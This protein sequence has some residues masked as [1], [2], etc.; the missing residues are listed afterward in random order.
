MRPQH[1]QSQDAYH[2][3]RTY[4]A[5]SILHP[6][7]YG[8]QDII[9]DST[10]LA[11]GQLRL[12]KLRAVLTDGD[13]FN[14][15]GLDDLPAEVALDA[16]FPKNASS[17]VF[18]IA[19]AALRSNARNAIKEG[20]KPSINSRYYPFE[21]EAFDQF[22]EASSG[23]VKS[24]KRFVQLMVQE[25][26]T[27]LTNLVC[28]P[29]LQINRK[30]TGGYELD[31]KYIPS[32]TSIDASPALLL[33]LRQLQGTLKAK[34]DA[35]YGLH[36]EPSKNVIEFRSGDVAS[37]WLLHTVSSAHASLA[38]L[39][40]HSALHPERLFG[41]LLS[42]A[43]GLLTFAKD[44]ASLK[45]GLPIY[46]HANPG[47]AFTRL[48]ALIR[49]LLDT[50]ISTRYLRINLNFVRTSFHQGRIET[51]QVTPTCRLYLAVS[52]SMAPQELVGA[53]PTQFKIGAPDDVED[54]VVAAVSCVPLTY[55]PQVPTAIP[56][57]PG[58][59]YFALEPR[60]GLYERM[61]KA[62]SVMLYA[63]AQNFADLDFELIAVK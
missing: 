63:P 38:H 57:R 18:V 33:M 41:Q 48:D 39:L 21:K 5:M 22:T 28:M 3:W 46:E 2:E 62:Q 60:G 13:I 47:Q 55:L 31:E 14:A 40:S 30:P 54:A 23:S 11:S 20:D 17:V 37:F 56:V 61:L 12:L 19:C 58:A 59:F 4:Q 29:V 10:G 9:I 25:K 7:F 32:S 6:Y 44:D 36:R 45:D 52:S 35:L 51:E 24:L 27:D 26:T 1:F 8:I 49:N 15:P 43:G 16:V 53:V 42:L 50:V 34:M